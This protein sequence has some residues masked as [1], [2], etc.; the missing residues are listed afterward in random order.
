MDTTTLIA[1]ADAAALALHNEREK[2]FQE[3]LLMLREEDHPKT[4][5]AKVLA[6]GLV[7]GAAHIAAALANG[8]YRVDN[9]R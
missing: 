7:E 2:L 1:L 3:L 4:I 5:K 9:E 8:V 6:L